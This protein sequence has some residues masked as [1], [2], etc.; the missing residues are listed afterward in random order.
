MTGLGILRPDRER[1]S[2][3]VTVATA[4]V[5]DNSIKTWRI[6]RLGNVWTPLHEVRLGLDGSGDLL[7]S[8][9]LATHPSGLLAVGLKDGH[10]LVFD[11][12]TGAVL[13]RLKA[14]ASEVWDLALCGPVVISSSRDKTVAIHN[15]ARS[16]GLE[17]ST[18]PSPVFSYS[19][20][21]VL[22]LKLS[23]SRVSTGTCG[24]PRG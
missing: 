16:R 20:G 8:T 10:I 7:S 18:A 24:P 4:S 21:W 17:A 2:A 23:P 22:R 1:Q 15:L 12:F 19:S 6:S 3:S 5:E 14:H 11:A 9:T 13:E